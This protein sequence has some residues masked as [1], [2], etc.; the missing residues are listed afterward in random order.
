MAGEFLIEG[1]VKIG[2]D[3]SQFSSQLQKMAQDAESAVN[4]LKST[5]TKQ[6]TSTKPE[7]EKSATVASGV[8]KFQ[9]QQ[10]GFEKQISELQASGA[11]TPQQATQLRQAVSK[12]IN[13]INNLLK[14][15]EST[16]KIQSELGQV[17]EKYGQNVKR[18]NEVVAGVR[19]KGGSSGGRGG[20]GNP[21]RPLAGGG[22]E[23]EEG[24]SDA[25]I[26]QR[27]AAAGARALIADEAYIEATVLLNAARRAL[28]A[29]I[30]AEEEA[31]V[32]SLRE[33]INLRIAR[34][35]L[36]ARTES[37]LSNQ[38][39][40]I[41]AKTS[42]A[43]SGL[44]IKAQVAQGVAG[45]Q[46]AEST[47]ALEKGQK[48]LAALVQ[49]LA[50]SDESLIELNAKLK[51][52]GLQ[53]VAATNEKLAA[54]ETYIETQHTLNRQK[55]EE[56]TTLA[57][58]RTVD[59]EMVGVNAELLNAR[60]AEKRAVEQRAIDE[61]NA[62][63]QQQGITPTRWQ[64]LGA[65]VKSATTGE[66]QDPFEQATFGSQLA[67]RGL[68]AGQYAIAGLSIRQ[69]LTTVTSMV[70]EAEKLEVVFGQIDLELKA[71]G[72]GDAFD[73]VRS[74]VLD[75]AKN[76]G[77][78]AD[79]LAG[80][81]QRTIGVYQNIS[82]ATAATK[83]IGQLQLVTGIPSADLFKNLIPA[84]LAFGTTIDQIGD[85]VIGLSQRFGTNNAETV[86]FFGRASEVASS[87]GL[88]LD[89]LGAISA[90]LQQRL[91]Q[92]GTASADLFDRVATS[93]GQNSEKILDIMGRIP[94]LAPQVNETAAA[95]AKGNTGQALLTIAQGW[96]KVGEDARKSLLQQV[97]NRREAATM[98]VLLD[99]LAPAL[100]T[101]G[102]AGDDS[103][104]LGTA[105]AKTQ[106]TIAQ[107]IARLKEALRQL[108]DTIARSGLS[109]FLK[110]VLTV[111][112]ALAKVAGVLLGV[113]GAINNTTHGLVGTFAA[114][115]AALFA[116]RFAMNA[117]AN[118]KGSQFGA[119]V[120]RG[121]QPAEQV[122][123]GGAAEAAG[124][125]EAAGVAGGATLAEGGT[126]A[127]TE[128]AAGGKAA[129]EALEAGAE[130]SAVGMEA[131]AG[132]AA[133]TIVAGG[134]GAAEQIAAAG[135][136]V[137]A[138][139]EAAGAETATQVEAAGVGMRARL[140]S[141]GSGVSELTVAGFS[142]GTLAFT[143]VVSA[144]IIAVTNTYNHAKE[145]SEKQ[146]KAFETQAEKLL[147]TG[148]DQQKAYI[149]H[150]ATGQEDIWTR[151]AGD[152]GLDTPKKEAG[153]AVIAA[154]APALTAKLQ[155]LKNQ[156]IPGLEGTIDTI[157]PKRDSWLEENLHTLVDPTYKI[158]KDRK[159]TID[160]L[161]SRLASGDAKAAADAKAELDRLG[162]DPK[163]AAAVAQ[164]IGLGND[165]ADQASGAIVQTAD[166]AVK[167]FKAGRNTA[168]ETFDNINQA[169]ARDRNVLA[170]EGDQPDPKIQEEIDKLI[171]MSNDVISTITSQA[172]SWISLVTAAG[173]TSADI[174]AA[175]QDEITKLESALASASLDP[176]TKIATVA[177]I[178]QI[179]QGLLK[180]LADHAHSA[181]DAYKLLL[182][183]T[184]ISTEDLIAAG[185]LTAP[186]AAGAAPSGP[187]SVPEDA[188]KPGGVPT[189]PVAG[190][191]V[192]AAPT[193]AYQLPAFTG[194]FGAAPPPTGAGPVPTAAAP[195]GQAPASPTTATYADGYTVDVGGVKIVY[196]AK[197]NSW[198][199]PALS[200]SLKAASRAA[201]QE[202]LGTY[203]LQK[204]ETR[205]PQ[206]Q[207]QI[208]LKS[209]QD[210]LA[211]LKAQTGDAAATKA[212]LDAAQ[213]QV[214]DAQNAL[215][216]A[217]NAADD[218]NLQLSRARIG[219]LPNA[220][221]DAKL[222]QQ[223]AKNAIAR[224]HGP[225]AEAQAQ[226]AKLKADQQYKDAMTAIADSRVN[227]LITLAQAAGDDV[228]ATKLRLDDDQKKLRDAIAQGGA[229]D[230]YLNPLKAQVAQDRASVIAAQLADVESTI[231]F[232]L[233]MGQLTKGQAI[234][235]LQAELPLVAGNQKQTRE[236]L[237]KIHQLM[238]DTASGL[239]FN[240]GDIKLP[241]LYEV[242]RLAGTRAAGTGYNDNRQI[243]ITMHNYNSTDYQGSIDQFV[244][245][246]NQPSR[247]GT[248]ASIYPT[249]N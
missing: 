223:D 209:A 30:I 124:A 103:G 225:V 151:L 111:A 159:I 142:L 211:Q 230:E 92:G 104:K 35:K 91:G 240:L 222:A 184:T 244:D 208:S 112:D 248:Y 22:G 143:G 242:N 200:E 126:A 146:G 149:E 178:L 147:N 134:V 109:S 174:A 205:D 216:D 54:D 245:L 58:E 11:V 133:E 162:K 123:E 82:Q 25:A 43:L 102:A 31:S 201:I 229:G 118:L 246:A 107:G 49:E 48:T 163:Y 44:D 83:A 193:P 207:A 233:E 125:T 171:A 101:E 141:A 10:R 132:A 42:R 96:S 24:I 57:R 214:N 186:A 195:T 53:L 158:P 165:V 13:Q 220:L 110:D 182:G 114:L 179:K 63:L 55:V 237:L 60:R 98:K 238:N 241:T 87:T 62:E 99:N 215:D 227:L 224:A 9:G 36:A 29:N 15:D 164:A 140:A 156:K 5:L 41:G 77:I 249:R 221:E 144:A 160:S 131:G 89:Q 197:T 33:I 129:G 175:T 45:E 52:Q 3:A 202:S 26:R 153:K 116:V 191:P 88:T 38:P 183:G 34:E 189:G 4:S 170:S 194:P 148:T 152:I 20:G 27:E 167:G 50:L 139:L 90:T 177:K 6:L 210:N 115:T 39:E 138:S 127:G 86:A 7:S 172:E 51:T 100:A 2:L 217:N 181:A 219:T 119:S 80:I 206:K 243:S 64:S 66:A 213:A 106:D 47:L 23:G 231:D 161:I 137:A 154:E 21:P 61:R 155:A 46:G 121:L 234:A 150:V 79:Q 157:K 37:E 176:A 8:T 12:Q 235:Q 105:A 188:W 69:V 232:Q 196:D 18:Q 32:L 71:I 97:A 75:I 108:G 199:I 145:A 128:V 228:T 236:L 84:A 135:P 120:R 136:E 226:I 76:L 113:F 56:A 40:F 198:K 1:K 72:Q 247:Y 212:E 122:A 78:A 187:L 130:Q 218:A 65:K 192:P 203:T 173:G 204:S 59:Q 239:Q 180:S 17:L 70:A 168:A 16:G 14:I 94:S 190:P 74:D 73:K 95:I 93:L 117:I 67:Q 68:I 19:G 28:S 85:K 185:V 81:E 166:E 169:L